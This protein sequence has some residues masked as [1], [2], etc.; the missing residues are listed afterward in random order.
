MEAHY[1]RLFSDDDGESRFEDVAV[2]LR[3]AFSAAGIESLP[4]APFFASEGTFWAGSTTAWNGDALHAAPRRLI[5][6]AVKG[7][8]SVTTSK[9]VTRRFT[10]GQVLL[11]EDMSGRGHSTKTLADGFA[12]YVALPVE[13]KEP[14]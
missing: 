5:I 1:T 3:H 13:R 6:I 10:P 14:P 7:E 8:Y 9:G 2:E 12:F 11:V 4:S